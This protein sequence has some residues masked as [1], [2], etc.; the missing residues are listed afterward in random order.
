MCK[1]GE[2]FNLEGSTVA[3]DIIMYQSGADGLRLEVRL[4]D[5][6]VWLSMQQMADLYQTTRRNINKFATSF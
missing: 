1:Q 3:S 6:T 4:Q 2:L 5:E